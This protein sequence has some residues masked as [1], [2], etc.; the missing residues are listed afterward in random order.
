MSVISRIYLRNLAADQFR[1]LIKAKQV[2]S[3][4]S[5]A[6]NCV[7]QR[8][9]DIKIITWSCKT[10]QSQNDSQGFFTSHQLFLSIFWGLKKN[11]I[12]LI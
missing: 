4:S 10:N 1:I 2:L 3:I 6:L 7:D 8:G 9:Q 11:T 12:L 5:D